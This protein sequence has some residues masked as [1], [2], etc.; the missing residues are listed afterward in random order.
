MSCALRAEAEEDREGLRALLERAFPGGGEGRLVDALRAD[1]SLVLSMVAVAGTGEVVSAAALSRMDAP[2]GSLCLGP[3]ATAPDRRRRGL[4]AAL[5]R[6]GL[7]GARPGFDAVFVVGDPHYYG[8]FGFRPA[9]AEGWLAP[10]P[11]AA[12]LAL[13]LRSGALAGGGR[14]RWPAPFERL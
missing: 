2:A 1:G 13:E 11:P 9:A 6:R 5:I 3:V 12:F 10:Y 8:R 7:E 14:A 4:A